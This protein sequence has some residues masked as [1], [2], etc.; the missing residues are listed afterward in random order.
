MRDGF[1]YMK[2]ELVEEQRRHRH[3]NEGRN[4]TEFEGRENTP[5]ISDLH[6]HE[7]ARDGVVYKRNRICIH[8]T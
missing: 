8:S 3:V 6:I 4:L 1:V 2:D 7:E 5:Y